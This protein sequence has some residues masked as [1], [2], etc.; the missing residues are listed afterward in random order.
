MFNSWNKLVLELTLFLGSEKSLFSVLFR[1][2]LWAGPTW[3]LQAKVSQSLQ[4]QNM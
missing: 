4:I 1:A 2:R 3:P